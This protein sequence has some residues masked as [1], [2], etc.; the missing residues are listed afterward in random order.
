MNSKEFFVTCE[1][2]FALLSEQYGFSVAERKKGQFLW[3]CVFKNDTT[4]V[5]VMYEVRELYVR[6]MICQLVNG[7]IKRTTGEIRPDTVIT[8]FGL[9]DLLSSR[10]VKGENPF[11]HTLNVARHTLSELLRQ[12]VRDL[13]NHGTDLLLGD[14]DIFDSLDAIVKN[15]AKQ[16]DFKEWGDRAQE[17]GW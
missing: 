4:G 16:A 7:R 8:C 10:E 2:S 9:D 17:F 3:E 1:K 12:Y 11:Y 14:F 13:E 5:R 15:R 6:V